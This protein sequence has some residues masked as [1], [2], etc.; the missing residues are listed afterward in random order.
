MQ[1]HGTKFIYQ[2]TPEKLEKLNG[3]DGRIT[4]TYKHLDDS[5][6]DDF[7]TVVFA[8]GRHPVTADLE[9]A[10]AGLQ[11]AKNGKLEV[12]KDEQTSVDNIYAIGDVVNGHAELTPTAIMAGRLLAERL[13]GK[14][15]KLMDYDNIPS[16]VFTPLEYG[17]C[18]LSEEQAKD[19][20]GSSNIKTYHA[21][22]WPHEWNFNPE[23]KGG[24]C[25]LKVIVDHT[26]DKVLGFH[27]LS[28]NAGEIT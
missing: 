13:F 1:A 15:N 8:I 9:L 18:G 19:Q 27:I 24:D 17:F 11:V 2:A 7:D 26:N 12:S 5:L 14:S 20:H 25:Y 23:R 21:A 4:V 6:T 28:P 16:T 10:K 3:E 22:F